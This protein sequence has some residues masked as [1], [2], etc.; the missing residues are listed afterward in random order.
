MSEKPLFSGDDPATLVEALRRRAESRPDR[1]AYTFLLD[2]ETRELHVTYGELDLQARAIA[3]RLQ[4]LGAAGERALL[5]Y[6]AGLQYAAAFLGCLYA[7]AVAVPA[8]PPRPNRPDSRI[9]AILADARARLVLTTSAVLPNAERLLGGEPGVHWLATDGLDTEAA[10]DWRQPA[11]APDSLAFLQY[12]S[13]STSVPKGVM[14]SHGNLVHNQR[15]IQRA[16]G[17]GEETEVV[18][19]L[20][21]YH[22]MGLIGSLLGSLWSGCRCVLMSP[23]DFLQRPLRWLEAVSRYGAAVSGG[24]NF[25]YDLCARKV[26]EE[27]LTALDLSGWRLAF[28]GAE[29]VR[30]ETLDR[31]AAAFAPAGFR[32]SAFYPCYGLAEATL[33]VSGGFAGEASGRGRFRAEE[34]GRHRAVPAAPDEAAVRTLVASGRPAEGQEVAVVDPETLRPAAAGEVGEIW[35]HGAS[36]TAGYWSRPELTGSTFHAATADG[37]APFL[38]TGDLGFLHGGELYVAG[39]LKDLIILR[40]RNLYP[41]DVE[42]T[43]E[44]SHPALRPGCG[45]AFAVELDGEERLVVVQELR[46][47]ARDADPAEVLEAI[48]RA[49]AEEHEAQLRAAVLIRTATLPKTSSGKVRRQ[50]CREAFLNGELAVVA[51]WEPEATVSHPVVAG[52]AADVSGEAGA[53]AWLASEVA[54]RTGVPLAAVDTRQPLSRLGLDSLHAMELTH[55]IEERLGLAVPM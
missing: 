24:P 54:A 6:P 1:L 42:L 35:I 23:V 27:D 49:V 3:A 43:V 34:L 22:D 13:G 39:R 7:G 10:A 14:V 11:I 50:A 12:T 26:R 4:A 37:E 38:R 47:E 2:G 15:L 46:R 29:P 28:N 8:Y 5:L 30:P 55:A 19:W 44:K 32:R 21:L 40:G 45:A 53:L 20:P 36:V 33:F 16:F 25:A 18:S 17:V 9:R 41:Q 52:P 51:A 31:F 48:R